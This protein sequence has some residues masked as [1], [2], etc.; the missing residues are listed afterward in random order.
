MRLKGATSDKPGIYL[1]GSIEFNRDPDSWRK[2]M[3][4]GLC[5]T[6]EVIIPDTMHPPF[7]KTDPEY[8]K[9]TRDNFILPDMAAVAGAPYFFVKLDKGVFKGAGTISELSLASWLGKDIVYWVDGIKDSDIP[10]WT[11]GC[12]TGG[13]R[14]NN[15]EEAI[16]VYREYHQAKKEAERLR[17]EK[18]ELTS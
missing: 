14:V 4:R 2:K 1:S 16:E 3:N 17:K 6:Y 12:L 8:Y 7:D 10:G 15:V 5:Q 13:T 11:L 9:W 18:Q